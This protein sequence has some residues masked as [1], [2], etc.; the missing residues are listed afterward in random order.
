MRWTPALAVFAIV[1]ACS[2]STSPGS[3]GGRSTSITVGNDFYSISPDT[4][5]S[6]ATITW[7]WAQPSNGHT[8]NWDSGPAALPPN[9]G[10][11]QTSGTYA[12]TL[13]AAGTYHYHCAVHG[14]AMSG[15]IVVQ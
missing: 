9:S 1:S 11:P 12:A 5:T 3:S 6:G 15:V 2:S 4:A 7:T 8:V 13:T 14:A 10:A